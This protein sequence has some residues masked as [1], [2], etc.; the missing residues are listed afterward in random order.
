MSSTIHSVATFGYEVRSIDVEVDLSRGLPQ[1]HIGGLGD[2]A[3]HESKERIRSAIKNSGFSFHD[4]RITVNLAP[5][6]LQKRGA[7]LDCAIA[8]GMLRE[9]EIIPAPPDGWLILGEL[10]LS[11]AVRP[12][13]GAINA[14]LLARDMGATTM[15]IPEQNLAEVRV[16][17]GVDYF[18]ARDFAD[19]VRALQHPSSIEVVHGSR[20]YL[21][22]YVPEVADA[23][24]FDDVNGHAHAK[25]ALMI[26]AAGKH[27]LLMYGPPGAGKSLLASCIRGL[28]PDMT[29]EEM[30]AT[31]RVYSAAG[32]LTPKRPLILTRPFRAPHHTSSAVSVL[33]GGTPPRPGEISLAHNGVLFLDEVLEFPR[34]VLE[35]LR[36]PLETR[37]ITINRSQYRSTFPADVLLIG[38]FNPCP[39]GYASDPERDCVCS[40]YQR[41]TYAKRLS[42]PLRDRCDLFVHVERPD[43]SATSNP[44]VLTLASA[45]EQVCAAHAQQQQRFSKTP[46]RCNAAMPLKFITSELPI[47]NDARACALTAARRLHLSPRAYLKVLRTAQTIADLELAPKLS[48]DHVLEALQ[49]RATDLL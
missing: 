33:G 21:A 11:G 24:A 25:R 14:A 44:S 4:G 6:S 46:F 15:I 8:A 47:D 13:S 29:E 27:H 22:S 34:I 30:I 28:L 26:A 10:A 7:T 17:E 32:E 39:C 35:G 49:F 12:V 40:S 38:A 42:G 9:Q 5:A 43:L 45:R 19:V 37:E 20:S 2:T 31:T 1:F 18:P 16:V 36:Q 23:V 41:I 3:I 48:K